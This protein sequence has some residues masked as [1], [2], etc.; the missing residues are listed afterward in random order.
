MLPLVSPS[1][2]SFS[3]FPPSKVDLLCSERTCWGHWLLPQLQASSSTN[4]PSWQSSWKDP[5]DPYKIPSFCPTRFHVHS[6]NL[7]HT[8]LQSPDNEQVNMFMEYTCTYMY[9]HTY[10]T[11]RWANAHGPAYI[12]TYIRMYVRTLKKRKKVLSLMLSK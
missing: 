6:I 9:I 2:P 11:V 3:F 5:H 4:L 12:R 8:H 7:H 10:V 1:P